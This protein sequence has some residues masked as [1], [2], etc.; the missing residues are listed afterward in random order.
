M[1]F[2]RSVEVIARPVH[3]GRLMSVARA[4][5]RQSPARHRWATAGVLAACAAT[6]LLLSTLTLGVQ[7]E[8]LP[9]A[10]TTA[11]EATLAGLLGLD[12]LGGAVALA[13]VP[14]LR[15]RTQR[16]A[17]LVVAATTAV[18]VLA[19][20]AALA[21]VFWV[22]ARRSVRD[23]VMV[24]GAV[25]L[26]AVAGERLSSRL[27]GLA[28]T[29]MWQIAVT[30]AFLVAVPGL[31][32]LAR[33]RRDAEAAALVREAAAARR[34]HA[35]LLG[36][37]EAEL[38]ESEAVLA[39]ARDAERTRIAREMHDSLAHQLSVIAVHAG[40]LEYRTDLD[41]EAARRA[42]ATVGS[43][44]RD[45]ASELRQVLGVL[46]AGDEGTRPLPDLSRLAELATAGVRLEVVPPFTAADLDTV[47]GPASRH[48]YRIVQEGLTN[49]RKH[50]AGREVAVRLAV[51]PGDS[52][53]IEVRNALRDPPTTGAAAPS[54]EPLAGLGSGLGLEGL[55]ERARLAGGWCRT[56]TE[57]G[58]FVLQAWLPW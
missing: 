12:L 10:L 43:A 55:A 24:G 5:R 35:A 27:L 17:A 41:P 56:G 3:Y 32:G 51:T 1:N 53:Q 44:A 29:P 33:G 6:G 45:A 34:E 52:V 22:A 30:A 14:V 23:L 8:E 46:R 54:P 7:L 49:A 31:V 57:N 18:S 37:R 21:T 9:D 19:G 48:A 28:D 16:W 58:T 36:R 4:L 20:P 26:A 13:L 39:S 38:R 11:Q 15:R 40:A 47:P 50:A 42:A 2:N 25:V